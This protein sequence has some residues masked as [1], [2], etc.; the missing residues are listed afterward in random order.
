MLDEYLKVYYHKKDTKI[1]DP[2]IFLIFENKKID[3]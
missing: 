2:N 3:D 1:F